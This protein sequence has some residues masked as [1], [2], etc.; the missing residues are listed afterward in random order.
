MLEL[1]QGIPVFGEL[2]LDDGDRVS[3]A[4]NIV[5]RDSNLYNWTRKYVGKTVTNPD[6]LNKFMFVLPSVSGDRRVRDS[7]FNALLDENKRVNEV[8]VED[9]LSWLNHPRRRSDSEKYIPQVLAELE[10]IQRTGDIF[11]PAGWL[12]SSLSG[13]TGKNAYMAV[14]N[15]LEKN[16]NYPKNLRLKIL[17]ASDHLR[18]LN[19]M[20]P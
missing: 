20:N 16:P 14:K 1:L 6:L 12:S 5:L 10:E 4:L 9:C 3:I 8:W 17:A 15:F 7:V 18:R 11:F 13:H 19:E 2:T